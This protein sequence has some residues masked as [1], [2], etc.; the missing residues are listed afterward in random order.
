MRIINNE[1]FDPLFARMNIIP[2]YKT[3][4]KLSTDN[5]KAFRPVALAETLF[6]L[7]ETVFIAH[8]RD[9]LERKMSEF[10]H[11]YRKGRGT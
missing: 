10:S 8:I 6:K 5:P 3:G 7:V 1:E 11:A 4:K 9:T 2:I